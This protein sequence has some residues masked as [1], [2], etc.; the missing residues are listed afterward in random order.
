[1]KSKTDLSVKIGALKLKNPIMPASG[2]YGFGE[3]MSQLFD[4]SRLGA[5]VSKGVTLPPRSGNDQPR[6]GETASGMFNSIGLENPGLDEVQEKKIPFMAQFYSPIIMNIN[7]YSVEEFALIAQRLNSVSA[8]SAL[9]VNISCP[10]VHD[11]KLPFGSNPEIAAQVTQAVRAV[12]DKIVIVKLTPNVT[13][14]AAIAQAVEAAG[15]D[16]ISLV[17]TFIGALII[18]DKIKIGGISG[19]EIKP[20]AL[21]RVYQVAQAVKIPVIGMGGISTL[22]DLLEFIKAGATAVAIGTANFTNPLIMI[23]LIDQL[24]QYCDENEIKNLAKIRGTLKP[25]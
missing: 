16:A 23:E 24:Q 20:M 17:N 25:F 12:Y 21:A 11:N 10:N 6:I 1:M 2:T 5:Q 22:S 19:R 13:D 18:G 8:V 4:P 14:I 15:A 3:E 9:E 7:G